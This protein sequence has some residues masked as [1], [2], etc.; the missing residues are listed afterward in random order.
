MRPRQNL[1]RASASHAVSARPMATPRTSISHSSAARR[2]CT[3]TISSLNYLSSNAPDRSVAHGSV[4]TFS[5]IKTFSRLSPSSP[6]SGR[7]TGT[8]PALFVLHTP[9]RARLG[10][11]EIE[12]R[13]DR[14][15]RPKGARA[16]PLSQVKNSL[17]IVTNHGRRDAGT[18]GAVRPEGALFDVRVCK[19][20]G[21]DVGKPVSPLRRQSACSR[22]SAWFCARFFPCGRP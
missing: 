10:T 14:C 13:D 20:Q 5:L 8:T 4:V 19:L 21:R 9:R 22:L 2:T 11:E 16:V 3:I 12:P 18:C 1:A 17:F 6:K 15:P 7:I